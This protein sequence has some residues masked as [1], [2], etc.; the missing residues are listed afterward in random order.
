MKK[1]R[2]REKTRVDIKKAKQ[3]TFESLLRSVTPM[4]P[5]IDKSIIIQLKHEI[6][7][8]ELNLKI[9][10]CLLPSS[11]FFS[12]LIL[13]LNFN[14]NIINTYN[15]VIPPSRLLTNELEFP[16]TLDMTGIPPGEHII[17]VEL[18]EKGEA[19][20][21][22]TNSSKY[23][24]IN[25]SPKQKE[26]NYIKVPHVRKI[27]GTFRIIM[28]NEKELYQKIE[29]SKKREVDSNRDKW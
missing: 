9:E 28:P 24:V 27:E 16:L 21:I 12:N 15:I 20:E 4:K 2:I 8:N 23:I 7:E 3:S 22:L 19:G 6:K 29:N 1:E 13:E 5:K 14:N 25:Y 10:F 26:D 18:T 17:K 11:T